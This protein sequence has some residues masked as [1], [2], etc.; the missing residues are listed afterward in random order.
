MALGPE[1]LLSL[2]VFMKELGLSQTFSL[3]HSGAIF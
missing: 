3:W 1:N 2:T